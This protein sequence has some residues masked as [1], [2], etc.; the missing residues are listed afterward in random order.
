MRDTIQSLISAVGI[1]LFFFGSLLFTVSLLQSD[2]RMTEQITLVTCMA[3]IY[4]LVLITA[5]KLTKMAVQLEQI[6]DN[7]ENISDNLSE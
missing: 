6:A 3:F 7:V 5:T 4:T 1:F 2:I